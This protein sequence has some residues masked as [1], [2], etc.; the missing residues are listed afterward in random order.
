MMSSQKRANFNTN[1]NREKMYVKMISYNR[2][3]EKCTFGDWKSRTWKNM[4]AAVVV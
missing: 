2:A 3:L 4:G 1:L